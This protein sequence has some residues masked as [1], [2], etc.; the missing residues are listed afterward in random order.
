M[1]QPL[2]GIKTEIKRPTI[3]TPAPPFQ[4]GLSALLLF[5]QWLGRRLLHDNCS[6][7]L[8][9]LRHVKGCCLPHAH[10]KRMQN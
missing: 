8:K 1:I 7:T 4:I 2:S 5:T 6:A 10:W 9:A 3:K